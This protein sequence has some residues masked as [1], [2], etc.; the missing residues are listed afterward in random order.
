MKKEIDFQI[1]GM[2]CAACAGRIEKGLNRLEGVEDAS[3]NLALETSHII[4][5]TE[6][7]TPDDLKRKVQSLGYDVVMEQAEF[8]IEGMTC[9]ACANRIEKKINRMDGVDHG[10]VNF[11]LETLQVTYHPG[12]TSANDIK[13]AVQS[14]GY[15]LIEPDAD[16]A[17]EGKKDHRQ[18]AIEKQTA[19]FLFSM[20][21]SLPLLWAMVSHFSF[22]SFIWLPEAFMNPWVQ[23]ALAAP[24]QFIVGWPFY[25][26]AYKALRNKSA[27]MDVLVALGTSA[28]FFYSL[29]ES[30][31]SAI[32][33]THEAALYYETSAVLITLIVLGKL[34]EA[35]AKGRSSEAI[36]KLMGLQAKEAVIE[37]DGK[38]MTVPISDVKV[39]DLVFVKPGEKVPVDGEIIEGTT[40][41]DESMITGESLP[42]DKTAG[43][44]VI[45]ATMNKN[46][47]IKIKATK[48][49]KETALSQI[50]RVVEQAQGSKAPIQRMADQISGIFVPIVVGI[51][52]LTFLIWFFFVDPGN[53]TSALET[54]IAVIVI[55]CPCALG[56]ATPTSIMAGSGRAAESGILFKGGEHLEVTQSLDTVVLDKT[57]TVTKGEPSLTDVLAYANWTEDTL[58][59]LAGSAEQQSEHPLARAI[60]DGMKERG[61]EAVEV[62][63][64]Q[65]DPGH[66]IEAKAAGHKLLIGTRKLLQKHHIRYEQIEASV[67]MLEEQ[68][69]TAMLVAIDGEVA[70]IV[71]VADTIKSSSP[72]A[73]ARLKEQGIHVVMMTGDNKLTAEAIAKQAGIDHVIAEVLPEEKAAHIAALQEQGKKVA[74]VGDGINDA[75]ALATA[76]IGMAVG[77]GTDVAMEAA[78][79]T[80]MTGD[81]HAIADALEF[82][83]KTMRNIKQNLFWALAYNCI[84]I[85]I[86][87]FGFLA[88]WLAG[89]A[90][91]FSSVSVVLNALRLQRLKPVREGVAE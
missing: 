15:S 20:I 21:L 40:A 59:Q 85:P 28:A 30:I 22:T 80:L 38:Q 14:I 61:L 45:G 87:A 55:A 19:R 29:Y 25:V 77:T 90:M 31:Q 81:L 64:F 88:P 69:K 52:V 5:E 3:V 56:L 54:F 32:R 43:D 68:G 7:L 91:A 46:G 27:N 12:Q 39:N 37:R 74:M 16:Q 72:Q 76:N 60:T 66:G 53:V 6:Q 33:G 75:P 41:I 23:L 13:D 84:G 70:G 79:I 17:E 47:F 36:Q 9:A 89:A 86:A 78:D 42:V 35:R 18:A 34:M 44:M 1:T 73:I 65:A 10:S 11:A 26:G 62:E 82:S 71:A 8:D 58:L 24:V 2:T 67:T 57:G 49:G 48:V 51:A 4:Y 50:I 83:K 63:A